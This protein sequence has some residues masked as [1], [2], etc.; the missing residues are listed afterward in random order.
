M[1][2]LNILQNQSQVLVLCLFYVNSGSMNGCKILDI[3]EQKPEKCMLNTHKRSLLCKQDA[4]FT[5]VP[6]LL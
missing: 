1:S 4:N 6:K 2:Y 3:K 5:Y